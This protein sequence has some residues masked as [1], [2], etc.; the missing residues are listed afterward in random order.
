[1]IDKLDWHL[2]ETNREEPFLLDAEQVE[3]LPFGRVSFTP[4]FL[5]AVAEK[6]EQEV[7]MAIYREDE[8]DEP[9]RINVD[10]DTS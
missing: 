9:C 8:Y 3:R 7:S 10:R 5:A 6:T 1:M 2:F 4:D